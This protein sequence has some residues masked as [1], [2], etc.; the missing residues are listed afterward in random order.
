MT[1][2]DG[3]N[4]F[5]MAIQPRATTADLRPGDTYDVVFNTGSGAT[6]IPTSL[7]PYFV[8]TP[9][10]ATYSSGGA[11]SSVSYPATNQSAGSNESN[12]I[13]LGS[14]SLTMSFWRPQ[15][16]AIPGVEAGSFV[17]IGHLHYGVVPTID[18]G[19]MP[20]G[21]KGF[22]SNLSGGLAEGAAGSDPF[23]ADQA[24]LIDNSDDARPDPARKL[25][26]T[27]DLAG[28]LQAHG[29]APAGQ[30][31]HL[32]IGASGEPRPG[33]MDTAMQNLIVKLP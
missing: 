19:R 26:F 9:A 11:E 30:T 4:V 24:P 13:H 5:A 1:S 10:L 2:H 7:S 29:V 28:C 18:F 17:D 20:F 25:G 6:H 27:L 8:T 12:P 23:A 21:C 3:H 33:G 15:R 14:G 32:G 22:Y 16:Q 31:V